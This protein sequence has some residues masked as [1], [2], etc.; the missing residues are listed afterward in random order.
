MFVDLCLQSFFMLPLRRPAEQAR[1]EP[2]QSSHVGIPQQ[3][4]RSFFGKATGRCPAP[5][6]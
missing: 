3:G 4:Y 1:K 6:L 2:P 5:A